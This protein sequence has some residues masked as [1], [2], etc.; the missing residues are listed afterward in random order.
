MIS[1][2]NFFEAAS[3]GSSL[4]FCDLISRYRIVIP[5]IQRDYVQGRDCA[6]VNRA[7]FVKDLIASL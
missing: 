3:R 4:S 6:K 2:G 5:K 1:Q 7:E